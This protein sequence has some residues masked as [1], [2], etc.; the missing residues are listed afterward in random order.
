[1][2]SMAE[3]CRPRWG[4]ESRLTTTDSPRNILPSAKEVLAI[5]AHPDDE[6]FGLGA[7]LG[8]LSELG[9]R[10]RVLCFTH[11]E[12]STLGDTGQ[13]LAEV[14]AE[15][16]NSAAAVLGI[17]DTKLMAYPDGHLVEVPLDELTQLVEDAIENAELL[18]VFDE[19]GITGHPDHSQATKAALQAA[20]RRKLPV[21][22]WALPE[23]IALQLNTEY[24]TTFVGRSED[25]IDITIDTDRELQRAAIACH[26]SQSLHNPILWRR[27]ELLGTREHLRWL[28]VA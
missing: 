2:Q 10:V 1:M 6:S 23:S 25:R 4:G 18:L 21:L 26:A 22:A 27:L 8:A 11:G 5:C 20:K 19:D 15:E 9:T 13:P 7:I 3:K 17:D 12:A 28:T 16:L 24:G 14:R